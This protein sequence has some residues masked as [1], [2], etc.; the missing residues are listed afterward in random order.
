[1]RLRLSRNQPGFRT[2][3]VRS[4]RTASELCG[5]VVT[6]IGKKWA[7][8]ESIVGPGTPTPWL[9]I[10][11]PATEEHSYSYRL[12]PVEPQAK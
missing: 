9:R 5:R 7:R 2:G 11:S 10:E 8:A 1:M 3:E 6:A 12:S 4:G